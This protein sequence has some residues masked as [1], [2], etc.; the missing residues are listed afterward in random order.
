[1]GRSVVWMHFMHPYIIS[2][3]HIIISSLNVKS[4]L[5]TA[6]DYEPFITELCSLDECRCFV[7]FQLVLW[8]IIGYRAKNVFFK[9]FFT[10]FLLM[11]DY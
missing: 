3:L 7:T 5:W 8:N 11:L 9:I 1:M 10:G 6:A 2:N 4:R